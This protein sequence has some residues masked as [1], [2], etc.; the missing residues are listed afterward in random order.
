MPFLPGSGNAHDPGCKGQL[1]VPRRLTYSYHISGTYIQVQWDTFG[2]QIQLAVSNV[3]ITPAFQTSEKTANTQ[4]GE[5]ETT[6]E[7]C[8]SESKELWSKGEFFSQLSLRNIQSP[9]LS[10]ESWAQKLA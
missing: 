1:N 3:L 2:E 10:L 9:P 7:E 5:L 6:L 8:S 4:G